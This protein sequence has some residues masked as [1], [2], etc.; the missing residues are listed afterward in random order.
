MPTL[1]VECSN[2]LRHLTQRLII[3]HNHFNDPTKLF[4]DLYLAEFLHHFSET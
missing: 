2:F 3:L 4:S 1:I